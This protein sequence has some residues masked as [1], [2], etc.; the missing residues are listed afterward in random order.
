MKSSSHPTPQMERDRWKSLDGIWQFAYDDHASFADPA[1]VP[2]D[3]NIQVPYPPESPASGIH[4]PGYHP[5]LWYRRTFDLNDL[6]FELG[7]GDTLLLHFGA[8]D[9]QASVWADGMRVAEHEGGHTPFT[10]DLSAAVRT[11]RRQGQ[12]VVTLIV[13]AEDDPHDLAKPRGK[14]DW[15]LEPH[16]IWY[17]RTSGIWQPVW[18]E[19]CPATHLT[20]LVWTCNLERWELAFR[21]GISGRLTGET[22][23]QVTLRLNGQ[24]IA[25]DDYAAV[26][27]EVSRTIGLRDGGI[28]DA[29][30]RLLWSPDHPQLIEA[31]LV[32]SRGEQVLDQVLSYTALRS[33]AVDEEHFM[34]NG[35]PYLLKLVLDQGY[36]PQGLMS[37]TDE[38]L[39]R[40][41]ELTR[42][43]GF[44]GARKHQKVENPRW[45][46]WCDVVGLLV[47]EELPSAYVFS[48]E[49]AQRL[50]REWM[51]VIR[52]DQSHPCIVAWV[53]FNESWGV[54][55][56]P[57]V[58]AQRELV[59]ALYAL[60][61]ALDPSRP[62]IGNDGWE[63]VV[64]DMIGVHDY[65]YL[66]AKLRERYGTSAA[67]QATLQHLRPGER[68]LTLPE[69]AG[70]QTPMI[71]KPVILSEFG[72][73]AYTPEERGGWGYNRSAD[74][75]ALAT[76]YEGLLAALHQSTALAG[77]CYTQ[78][79]DTFQEKNG[80][81]Y[82]DRTPKVPFERI[83][84]ANL[85][86][87]SGFDLDADPVPD[88]MGYHRRWRRKPVIQIQER[89]PGD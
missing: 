11:A 41:V 58:P 56:L 78:L 12:T 87:R 17:P 53:P 42:L 6:G 40:D 1:D 81:L 38:Q 63:H 44:N 26:H 75:E 33:A 30:R 32:L 52:R 14:Q 39:R 61:K 68:Q 45:L 43:L 3:L 19:A 88:P 82:E 8:V 24:V 57:L 89:Q 72:G 69:F 54:P 7:Q 28:D 79:T 27:A 74:A 13:R 65:T 86:D 64:T 34:L 23:L 36:W 9:Y 84:A 62:V 46:Y 71:P 5:V 15:E 85:G 35:R 21:A 16:N 60:T 37:A 49:A 66:P 29:R 67:V 51:E 20:S 55:D 59:R 10:A 31:E 77:F 22:R 50:T 73:A 2:F 83:A 25:R 80:L 47:W 76:T 18:L 70:G 48:Q 4:D